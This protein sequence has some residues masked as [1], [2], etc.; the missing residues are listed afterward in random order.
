MLDADKQNAINL[1]L[2]VFQPSK[3]SVPLWALENDCHLHSRLELRFSNQL[4]EK[5]RPLVLFIQNV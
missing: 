3:E 5:L 2:G 4:M 1:F